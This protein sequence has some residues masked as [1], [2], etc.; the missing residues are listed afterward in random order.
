MDGKTTFKD[1]NLIL[2]AYHVETGHFLLTEHKTISVF[3]LVE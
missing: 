3:A 1:E 2:N